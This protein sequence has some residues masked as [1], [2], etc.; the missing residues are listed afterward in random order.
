MEWGLKGPF[1]ADRNR[2]AFDAKGQNDFCPFAA[3][4]VGGFNLS[5]WD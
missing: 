4:R 1:Q 2:N 5:Y 3:I